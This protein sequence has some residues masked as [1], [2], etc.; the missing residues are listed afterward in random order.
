MYFTDPGG[1]SPHSPP[2]QYASVGYTPRG[3]FRGGGGGEAIGA[4]ASP[5]GLNFYCHPVSC[6]L[7]LRFKIQKQGILETFYI[8]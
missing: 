6:K 7:G 4:K 1:L 3:V 5:L 2:P 8:Y